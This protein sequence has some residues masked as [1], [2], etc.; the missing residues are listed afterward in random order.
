MTGF[1]NEHNE[2]IGVFWQA[3]YKCF[4]I[5]GTFTSNSSAI[6]FCGIQI[7]SFCKSTS[8]FIAPLGVL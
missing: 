1:L 4:E 3:L 2:E 6:F 5:A 7:V 8:T